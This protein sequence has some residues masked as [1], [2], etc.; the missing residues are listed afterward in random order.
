MTRAKARNRKRRKRKMQYVLAW[1]VV[2]LFE[3]L[4]AA[5]PTAIA[6]VILI[7]ITYAERGRMAVGGEWIAIMVIFCFTY[8]AIHCWVCDRIY[9]EEA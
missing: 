8:R 9:G 1:T 6:A 4:I 7:P 3:I 2:F 5:A